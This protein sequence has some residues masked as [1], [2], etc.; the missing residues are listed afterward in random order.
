MKQQGGAGC[1]QEAGQPEPQDQATQHPEVGIGGIE[2]SG[3]HR[4]AVLCIIGFREILAAT[5]ETLGHLGR[6]Q[7]S[8]IGL[9]R[10]RRASVLISRV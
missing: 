9:V 7:T 6:P 3:V 8:I 1:P 5:T 2:P 4:D 10:S